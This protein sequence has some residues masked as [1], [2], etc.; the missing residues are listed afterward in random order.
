MLVHAT[1]VGKAILSALPDDDWSRF[2]PPEPFPQLTTHTHTTLATLR[3]DVAE[4]RARG[5]AVDAEEAELSGIC[6]GAPI[7]G[8]TGRP[9]AAIS[10][11]SVTGRLP[12]DARDALGLEVR[13]WCNRL[14]GE[15][16]A[17]GQGA[18]TRDGGTQ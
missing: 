14:T 15:L 6:V 7:L 16:R 2:L 1:S 5:W 10:V 11:C 4:C 13:Q 17:G 3:A 18:T 9:V 8:R 12:A